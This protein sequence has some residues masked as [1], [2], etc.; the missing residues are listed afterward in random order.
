[1]NNKW[2]SPFV[3]VILT[4]AF[5]SC[6]PSPEAIATMTASAWTPTPPPTP[7]PTP[8]PYGLSVNLADAD[9]N[10]INFAK[11]SVAELGEDLFEVDNSGSVSFQN[12][13]G[14]SVSLSVSASGYLPQDISETIERGENTIDVILEVDPNGLLPKDACAEGE[15][16][17]MVE[18]MQDQKMQGWSNLSNRLE[19]GAPGVEIVEDDQQP[20]N[21]VFK[22]FNT[23]DTGPHDIGEY[24]QV[25]QDAVVRFRTRNNSGQHLHAVWHHTNTG[26]YIAFIYADQKGGRVD[27]FVDPENFTAFNY[28]GII[29]DG[30]WHTIEISTF[31]DV[32]SLWIDGQNRGSW[33]DKQPL[34]PGTFTLG[35]D[36]WEPDRVTEFDDF[37]ICGLSAP[38]TSLYTEA[39]E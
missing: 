7:T 28:G 10:P 19:S 13:P 17:I 26:R 16:L 4:L 1:M 5:V 31:E 27:K 38:F 23:T 18:D 6:G 36:Y 12:L 20:G 39:E 24:D 21:W 25:L 22:T 14:D 2:L 11:I 8:I 35:A 3:I 32:Y 30:E 29:G 9:G 33:Q 15:T 37:S 34:P